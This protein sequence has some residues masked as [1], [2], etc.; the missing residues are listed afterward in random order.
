MW[1]RRKVQLGQK[2]GRKIGYPTLNFNVGIF[3]NY[4]MPGVYLSRVKIFDKIYNGIL[5]F[6]PKM[7]SKNYALEV[8]VIGF[9][10]KIYGEFVSFTIVKKI[11]E[12]KKFSSFD[13]LKKQIQLDIKSIV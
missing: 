8:F 13:T 12:P 1:Y 9:S 2:L 10:K 4:N 11:R 5:Y 3:T 7:S 6:G